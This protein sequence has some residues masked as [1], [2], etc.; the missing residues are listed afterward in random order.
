MI[1]LQTVFRFVAFGLMVISLGLLGSCAS[2][3]TGLHF[4]LMKSYAKSASQY[5]HVLNNR[6]NNKGAI[7]M[8]MIPI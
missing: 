5:E 7:M 1:C 2:K 6:P 8:V 4:Y 3:N